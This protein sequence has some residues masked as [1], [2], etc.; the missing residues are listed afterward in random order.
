MDKL[1][2]PNDRNIKTCL[3]HLPIPSLVKGNEA[4]ERRFLPSTD[5]LI[6]TVSQIWLLGQ[7][8]DAT[9]PIMGSSYFCFVTSSECSQCF[10]MKQVSNTCEDLNDS[11]SFF[12]CSARRISKVVLA[13]SSRN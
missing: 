8:A 11:T 6:Y 7:G 12:Y 13:L 1:P 10:R 5:T 2:L 9:S 4:E 3:I